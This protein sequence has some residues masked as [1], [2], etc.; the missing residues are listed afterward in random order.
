[1]IY[2]D[3][4]QDILEKVTQ[5]T[6]AVKEEDIVKFTSMLEEVDSIFLMGLGRSGLVAKAF[7]MRLMHLGLSVYVVGETTT[8]AITDKDCLIAISGSGETSYIISTTGIAK[9]VGSKIIAI[10]SYPDSTLAKRSD[11]ILQLQGRTKIDEEP[12]Y[13]RRQISGLHNSLSP[14]GTIFEI[15]ALIFLDSVIAQMM[16]DL[17]QTEKDLKARHTVLE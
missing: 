9:Q 2:N 15:S 3:A 11:L 12:N 1:M 13:A 17:G 10:T 8:P 5:T 14:M 4:L 6:S 16:D 7:A